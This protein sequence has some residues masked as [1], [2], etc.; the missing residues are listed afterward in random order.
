MN[1]LIQYQFLLLQDRDEDVWVLDYDRGPLAHFVVEGELSWDDKEAIMLSLL[2]EKFF[3][4][5]QTNLPLAMPG[6]VN[7]YPDR[8]WAAMDWSSFIP[9]TAEPTVQFTIPELINNIRKWHT[10]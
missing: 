5:K 10:T 9:T 1:T 3:I 6:D 7:P 4:P 2:D 8:V